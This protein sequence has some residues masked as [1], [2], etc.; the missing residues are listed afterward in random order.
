MLCGTYMS[1]A[2]L[3]HI[4]RATIDEADTLDR[5]GRISL[6]EFAQVSHGSL[7]VPCNRLFLFYSGDRDRLFLFYS[8]DRLLLFLFSEIFSLFL[9][10]GNRLLLFR[11]SALI[12]CTFYSLPF[13]V[14]LSI[15]C[16]SLLLF[17]FTAIVS[18]FNQKVLARTDITSKMTLK[19][20]F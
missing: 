14:A 16:H 17:L 20:L 12:D 11:F 4:V 8:G 10:S 15:H 9:F 19:S 13:S 18:V 1:D 5:D 6:D 7:S 2:Q 3:D